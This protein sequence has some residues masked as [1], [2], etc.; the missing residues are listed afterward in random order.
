MIF[1]PLLLADPSP[2]LRLLVLNEL[3]NRPDTDNEIKE[4]RKLQGKDPWVVRFLKLQNED[5]SWRGE[6]TGGKGQGPIR[7]TAQAL[8]GLGYL[9]L[10]SNHPAIKKG[11]EYLYSMQLKNGSWPLALQDE[12]DDVDKKKDI[13]YHMVPLQTAL[14]LLGLAR[15]GYATDPRSEN[16]YEWLIKESLPQGGWPSGKHEDT[17]ILMGG[18]RRL[19]HS[20]YGCRTNTT[21]CVSAFS[22]HSR[23]R[24]SPIAKR[25]LDLLLA[26]EHHQAHNLGFEVARIIGA[27]QTRG[28]FTYFQKYDVGQMLD[29]CWRI[30]AGMADGRV[31]D[32]VAFVRKLQGPYGLWEYPEYPEVSRWVTFDLLRSLSR[33]DSKTDWLSLEPRTPFQPYPK[34][35]R[36]F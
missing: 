35:V 32:H 15:A 3:F 24:S 14:P 20:K 1:T 17:Y 29:L 30:G 16:A 36:R 5:G 11:A 2:S 22:L 31:A 28:F 26:Q 6:E 25:G 10:S 13:K 19:A 18:Y 9:G 21:A 23:R 8:M 33:L 34:R 12:I 4:L 7:M 27:E